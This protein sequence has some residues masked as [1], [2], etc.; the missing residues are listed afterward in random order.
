MIFLFRSGWEEEELVAAWPFPAGEGCPLATSHFLPPPP[1]SS[2]SLCLLSPL[3][4]LCFLSPPSSSRFL[5]PPPVPPTLS[6]VAIAGSEEVSKGEQHSRMIGVQLQ[7]FTQD[8][9]RL[10][11]VKSQQER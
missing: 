6:L 7:G 9:L 1:L 4:S 10:L 3:S 8:V 5:P 11:G 2:S